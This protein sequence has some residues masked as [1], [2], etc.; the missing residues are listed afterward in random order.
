MVFKVL[1]ES[2][3]VQE[4]N[5]APFLIVLTGNESISSM[6]LDT[7]IL[8][9]GH[10]ERREDAELNEAPKEVEDMK[11]TIGESLAMR[12][13]LSRQKSLAADHIGSSG[14]TTLCDWIWKCRNSKCFDP[15]DW[16]YAMLAIA[17]DI[18]HLDEGQIPIKA[19]CD[20]S[21]LDLYCDI[22]RF[23][24]AQ[25]GRRF[26]ASW[27]RPFQEAVQDLF[28]LSDTEIKSVKGRL[29]D[30]MWRGIEIWDKR[31]TVLQMLYDK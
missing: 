17:D 3:V 16:V 10:V 28:G 23:R 15:R 30:E 9:F 12:L 22:V 13:M 1:L 29:V 8:A 27:D 5:L 20:K 11:K 19:D 21:L 7:T 24:T 14:G 4:I 6:E 26:E 18:L 31:P 2:S 25:T